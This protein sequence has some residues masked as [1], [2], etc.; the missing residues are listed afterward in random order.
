MHWTST[1]AALILIRDSKPMG[2]RIPLDGMYPEGISKDD[3]EEQHTVA[4]TREDI[5]EGFVMTKDMVNLT[6][7]HSGV[8][9]FQ[10]TFMHP[11]SHRS[12]TSS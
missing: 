1:R 12:L 2:S 6:E 7:R 9:A 5:R 11:F 4:C 3:F 8:N 10:V